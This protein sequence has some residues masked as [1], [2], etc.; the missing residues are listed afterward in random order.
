MTRNSLGFFAVGGSSCF[1]N[2]AKTFHPIDLA[3]DFIQSDYNKCV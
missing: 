2:H 1:R 3:V